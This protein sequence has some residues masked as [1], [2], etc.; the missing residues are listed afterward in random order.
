VGFQITPATDPEGDP[1]TYHW[2]Y[3]DFTP[4][5]IGTDLLRPSHTY[6][7]WGTFHLTL[8]VTDGRGGEAVATLDVLVQQS[9]EEEEPVE[10]QPG[11]VGLVL[12]LTLLALVAAAVMMYL[13]LTTPRKRTGGGA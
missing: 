7:R 2:D 4:V 12:L 8:T 11:P 9:G 5:D 10:V 3:G 13:Y 6:T 1:L